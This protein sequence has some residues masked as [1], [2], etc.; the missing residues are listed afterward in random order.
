MNAGPGGF[1]NAPITKGLLVCTTALTLLAGVSHKHALFTLTY[2]DLRRLQLWRLLTSNFVFSHPGEMI[3]GTFL[4]YYFRV[5]ERRMGSAKYG[6]YVF[7]SLV[8]STLLQATTL[9]A[10]RDVK[11]LAPGPYGLVFSCLVPFFFDVP[12]CERFSIFGLPFTDKVFIYIAAAQL[13][14][15]PSLY[16]LVPGLCGLIAGFTIRSDISGIRSFQFPAVINRAV[17]YLATPLLG[18]G[19]PTAPVVARRPTAPGTDARA[20]AAGSGAMMGG[21]GG[22]AGSLGGRAFGP[23]GHRPMGPSSPL[24]GASEEAVAALVAMGF[25]QSAARRALV[26]TGNDISSATHI[27]LEGTGS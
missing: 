9:F 2:M 3:F 25:D 11:H 5:F 1:A 12:P 27:L 17:R 4:L 19:G 6:G 10:F 7:L 15:S 14:L 24:V 8:L 16:S 13:L 21:A 26:L 23:G 18:L 20:A 22:G